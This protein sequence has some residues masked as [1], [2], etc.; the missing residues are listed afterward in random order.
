MLTVTRFTT[1]FCES[2]MV[3][4]RL[5]SPEASVACAVT[6]VTAVSEG[7]R[8]RALWEHEHTEAGDSESESASL[9]ARGAADGDGGLRLARRVNRRL[10]ALN[11]K[12][13][14]VPVRAR[15]VKTDG[16]QNHARRL[17]GLGGSGAT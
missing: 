4:T 12:R 7:A 14:P 5:I 2:I 1:T 8:A 11:L 9:A 13:V 3:V 17:Q 6:A 10:A 15:A 16:N